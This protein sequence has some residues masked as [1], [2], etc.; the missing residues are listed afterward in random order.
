MKRSLVVF[1]TLLI[2]VVFFQSAD[3]QR[4]V[5]LCE[6][7]TD[8]GQPVGTDVEFAMNS[9]GGAV[10]IL[11]TNGGDLIS[12]SRIYLVIDKFSG[13][14]YQEIKKIPLT[15]D[16]TKAWLVY[17]FVC[18]E[19]GSYK[20]TVTTEGGSFL[21]SEFFDVVKGEN[22]TQ[23]SGNSDAEVIFCTG[24]DDDLNPVDIATKFYIDPEGGGY[25]YIYVDNSSPFETEGLVVDFWRGND[26]GVFV[27]TKE[28]T[29]QS[30]WEATY[31]KY[32][33][34]VAGD[35]KVMVYRKDESLI[36]TGYVTIEYK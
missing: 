3:A 6:N 4:K 30:Q 14:A 1:L 15:P 26:Y 27:E 9:E 2:C 32:T 10:Y 34:K 31:F 19:T 29:I 7:Y 23:H 24:L 20:V 28:L 11:Y 35:Y 18:Y 13:T 33:F 36:Q 21:A 8:S 5:Y 12:D 16:N 17:D 25:I 22:E